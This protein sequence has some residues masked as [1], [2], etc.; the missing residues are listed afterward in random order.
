[1]PLGL[2]VYVIHGSLDDERI[3]LT[4]VFWGAAPFA[5]VMLVVLVALTLFPILSLAPLR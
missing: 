3:A 1:P 2:S 4:D 5:L